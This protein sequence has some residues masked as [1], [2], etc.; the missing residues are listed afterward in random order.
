MT[1]QSKKYIF[2]LV[3]LL[4][5]LLGPV[6][7]LR[8]SSFDSFS[9]PIV[10]TNTVQRI[11]GLLAFTLLSI[12]IVLG[13]H[14][15]RWVQIIG[16]RAYKLHITQGL[17]AYGFMFIHPLFEN[18]IVYQVSKSITSALLVFIPSLETQR[19]IFLVFGRSAFILASI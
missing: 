11:T 8:N 18:V 4:I 13:A 3:W 1:L 17:V 9:N 7:V 5:I 6:T 16:A 14:M 15:N 19:G 12:Q 10:L 2:S